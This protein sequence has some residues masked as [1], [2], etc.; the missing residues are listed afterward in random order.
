[1]NVLILHNPLTDLDSVDDADVLDQVQSVQGALRALGHECSVLPWPEDMRQARGSVRECPWARSWDVVFNLVESMQGS[2]RNALAVPVLLEEL[3][4]AFTGASSWSLRHSTSKL[5]AKAV[6]A[7]HCLPT[8]AWL[9]MQGRGNALTPGRFIVKS[10]WEHAS[11]GLDE[12]NVVHVSSRAGLLAQMK[13][14]QERLGK[15][16]FAEEYVPGRE[17]N[18]A[19]VEQEGLP[20]V[21]APAEIQFSGYAKD[22]RRVVGFRAKWQEQS[23]EYQNTRRRLEFPESDAPLLRRLTLTAEQCWKAF[24]LSGYARIDLRVD[25]KGRPWIIDVNANPCLSPDAGFQASCA[26]SGL[27][28]PVVVDLLLQSAVSRNTAT[29]LHESAM[30]GLN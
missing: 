5:L 14:R 30:S 16:C 28:F 17:F 23:F 4:T 11:F 25:A 24:A 9:D 20:R 2:A 19:V 15:E 12:D 21:P 18:L 3:G 29:T 27:T 1:M 10:V 13:A 22:K 8:P 7:E 6:L 26:A